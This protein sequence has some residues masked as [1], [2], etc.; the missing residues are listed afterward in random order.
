MGDV[1]L[2][3]AIDRVVGIY[4]RASPLFAKEVDNSRLVLEK[5]LLRFRFVHHFYF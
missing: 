2:S 4:I 5:Q 1:L 3:D